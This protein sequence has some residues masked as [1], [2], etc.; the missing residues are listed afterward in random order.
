VTKLIGKLWFR[1]F[2]IRFQLGRWMSS[3]LSVDWLEVVW[4]RGPGILLRKWGVL[5]LDAFKGLFNPFQPSDAMWC[6]TF[7]LFLIC[8]SF[9]Q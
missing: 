9:A 3:E 7:H 2:M 1:G 4:N 5:V 6:H 8:M